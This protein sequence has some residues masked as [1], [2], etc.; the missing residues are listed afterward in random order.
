VSV[1]AVLRRQDEASRSP[2]SASMEIQTQ[3]RGAGRQFGVRGV[4]EVNQTQLML[5]RFLGSLTQ[6]GP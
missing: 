3:G 5:D 4:G 1:G 6:P 2:N